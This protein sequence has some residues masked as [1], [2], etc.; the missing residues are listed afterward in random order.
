M[1]PASLFLA[2]RV[3]VKDAAPAVRRGASALT[4]G[5]AEAFHA[6]RADGRE[7]YDDIFCT[8]RALASFSG[9]APR[10]GTDS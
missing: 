10:D 1:Q 8:S 9:T 7:P 4:P 6:A 5:A 2:W 3:T